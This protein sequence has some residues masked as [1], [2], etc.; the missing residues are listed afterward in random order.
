MTH[1]SKPPFGA[2]PGD[3]QAM[4][5]AFDQLPEDQQSGM[6]AEIQAGG[7]PT[8]DTAAI[9][10]ELVAQGIAQQ[11]EDTL[12]EARKKARQ[13]AAAAEEIPGLGGILGI[14]AEDGRKGTQSGVIEQMTATA[15]QT[16][17][18]VIDAQPTVGKHLEKV[19]EEGDTI[20]SDDNGE[21][22]WK[23]HDALLDLHFSGPTDQSGYYLD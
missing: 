22:W 5:A 21:T 17:I 23:R 18:P 12:E 13:L 2:Q 8:I 20:V 9:R 6:L 3:L 4:L 10:H 1:E 16:E 19:T 11:G 15:D 7:D 14:L